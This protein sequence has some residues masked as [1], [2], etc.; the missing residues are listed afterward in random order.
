ME[1]DAASTQSV[2]FAVAVVVGVQEP[3]NKSSGE[4]VATELPAA[5]AENTVMITD[6]S[7]NKPTRGIC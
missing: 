2:A 6:E 3:C 4:A 5:G 7:S 1:D